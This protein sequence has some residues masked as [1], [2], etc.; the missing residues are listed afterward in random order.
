MSEPYSLYV[1]ITIKKE[2]LEQFFKDKPAKTAIDPDWIA[3]WNSRKMYGSNPLTDIRV[4]TNDTNRSIADAFLGVRDMM[5]FEDLTQPGVWEYSSLFFSENYS[6]IL[7]ALSWLSSMAAYMDPEEEGVA[8]IYNYFWDAEADKNVMAHLVFKDQQA[9]I[10]LT[11]SS[12]E[13]DPALVAKANAALR[14]V[15]EKLTADYKGD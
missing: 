7:P 11:S 13:M 2:S 12:T 6:D 9:T 1:N 10:Q 3:W 5:T 14:G 4:Y 8:I 15:W